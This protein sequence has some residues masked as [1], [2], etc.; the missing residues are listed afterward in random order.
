MSK[1]PT[2]YDVT[3]KDGKL[4]QNEWSDDD[5]SNSSDHDFIADKVDTGQD[6]YPSYPQPELF[7]QELIDNMSQ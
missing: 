6:P 3:F 1:Y 7:H 4:I 2:G 5:T